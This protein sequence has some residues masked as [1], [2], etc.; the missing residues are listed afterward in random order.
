MVMLVIGFSVYNKRYGIEVVY[1]RAPDWL[2][3]TGPVGYHVPGQHVVLPL[4]V[5]GASVYIRSTPQATSL[6]PPKYWPIV[7]LTR[8]GA[9]RALM[10]HIAGH[11]YWRCKNTRS[12]D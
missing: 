11:H 5:G 9:L 2:R 1:S 10:A 3:Y 4:L 8:E 6:K 12:L 7:E